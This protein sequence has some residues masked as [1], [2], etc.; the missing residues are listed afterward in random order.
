MPSSRRPIPIYPR[1]NACL[2]TTHFHLQEDLLSSLEKLTIW[3][4][5]YSI[6]IL[7]PPARPST[8]LGL[9]FAVCFQFINGL[10]APDGKSREINS[11][12]N[13]ETHIM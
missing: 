8:C 7:S 1:G 4:L 2:Y 12:W 5:E 6:Y 3:G 13:W 10:I 9:K 11:A